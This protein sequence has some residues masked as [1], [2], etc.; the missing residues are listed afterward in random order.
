MVTI[1]SLHK[2]RKSPFLVS[3]ESDKLFLLSGHVAARYERFRDRILPPPS[4]MLSR[5]R[6]DG[7]GSLDNL[8]D[9]RSVTTELRGPEVLG[10]FSGPPNPTPFQ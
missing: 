6:E 8:R 7:A 2:R 5:E 9:R 3:S 1:E 10:R 4:L